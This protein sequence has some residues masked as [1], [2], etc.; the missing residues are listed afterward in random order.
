MKK[1]F[2]I[3]A[4]SLVSAASASAIF[5]SSG[6]LNQNV[7]IAPSHYVSTI[8]VSG[9]GDSLVDLSVSLNISG[10]YNGNLYAYLSYGGENVILLNRIGVTGSDAFGANDAG[11]SITL[12]DSGSLGDIHAAGGGVLSGNWRPDGRAISP[13][14]TGAQFDAATR[15]NAGNPLAL[16]SGVNPNGEW[17]LYIADV[18][19]VNSPVLDSWGLELTAVPEPT[20]WAGII[21][22]SLFGSAC[23]FRRLRPRRSTDL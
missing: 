19:G 2:A 4:L 5:F 21:F 9:L 12:S 6:T 11:M 10:G 7:P 16:F 3:A 14:S 13:F 1:L 23:L 20:T 22:A 18:E 15:Q 17:K 8:S